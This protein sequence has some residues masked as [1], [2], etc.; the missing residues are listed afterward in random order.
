MRVISKAR[1]RDFW[2]RRP[3]ALGAMAAWHRIITSCRAENFAELRTVFASADYV[4]P[5][6]TVFNVGGNKFRIVACI[7]YDQQKVFIRGVL[8]HREYDGWTKEQRR[9]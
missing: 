4:P 6:Y 7:H 2:E 3:E 5:R 1:L 9:Q 8:T